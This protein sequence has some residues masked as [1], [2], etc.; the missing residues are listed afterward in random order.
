MCTLINDSNKTQGM[1]SSATSECRTHVKTQIHQQAEGPAFPLSFTDFP[2]STYHLL[3]SVPFLY[4]TSQRNIILSPSD[5][6]WPHILFLLFHFKKKI[7][8]TKN[9]CCFPPGCLTEYC[10]FTGRSHLS[11]VW[12]L[13]T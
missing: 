6:Y 9:A 7:H 11:Y 10:V 3:P 2:T 5:G 12:C 13:K 4:I 1:H 8:P